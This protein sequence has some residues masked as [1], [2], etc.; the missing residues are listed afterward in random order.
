MEASATRY[1][2]RYA[3]GLLPLFSVLGLGRGL[4]TVELDAD[5]LRVGMGWALRARIPRSSIVGAG[6]SRPIWWAIGVHGDF[7]GD[8]LVNGSSQGIVWIRIDPPARGRV[9][10]V[11]VKL[12]RLG[13]GLEEP[14]GF[15]AALAVPAMPAPA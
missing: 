8:W 12:R 14:E 5:E 1:R 6:R 7:H 10:G 3:K 11:P 9:L 15:L 2:I 4:S 13:L